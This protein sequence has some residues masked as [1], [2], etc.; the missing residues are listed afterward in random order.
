MNSP[1]TISTTDQLA[2]AIGLENAIVLSKIHFW[3]K[4]M[5]KP[6][7]NSYSEWLEQFPW[8]NRSSIRRSIDYLEKNE[9]IKSELDSSNRKHYSVN[10]NHPLLKL[11]TPS[12]QNEQTSVQI[13]QTSAHS[14]HDFQATYK[15]HIKTHNNTPKGSATDVTK[16]P[17]WAEY[18]SLYDWFRRKRGGKAKPLEANFKNFQHWRKYYD[19]LDMKYAILMIRFDD[20]WCQ[21]NIDLT[22]ILRQRNQKQEPVDYIGKFMSTPN[23]MRAIEHSQVVAEYNMLRKWFDSGKKVPDTTNELALILQNLKIYDFMQEREALIAQAK[24]IYGSKS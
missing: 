3:Q 13:E 5:K 24:E 17:Q 20:F 1:R 23:T 8:M 18:V 12:A 2:A 7:Y 22:V 4:K 16:D 10:T 6:V 19:L 11:S 21:S 9:L 14:E 15:T